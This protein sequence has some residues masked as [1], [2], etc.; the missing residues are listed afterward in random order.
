MQ[1]CKHSGVRGPVFILRGAE[2]VQA[3][4]TAPGLGRRNP[5]DRLCELPQ[6]NRIVRRGFQ[7]GAQRHDGLLRMPL[8]QALSRRLLRIAP[9]LPQ[10]CPGPVQPPHQHHRNDQRQ[11]DHSVTGPL[12]AIQG[13][14]AQ[15]AH[16][17]EP[18]GGLPLRNAP[19]NHSL[20]LLL[21]SPPALDH[22]KIAQHRMRAAFA[23]RANN[24]ASFR[25]GHLLA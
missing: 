7:G 2:L 12:Q 13:I 17:A 6:Q 23:F 5:G 10:Q 1:Q 25:H 15:E 22:L 24:G 18:A 3:V 21:R 11:T 20:R 14:T 16:L 19:G 4:V 8:R 9:Q